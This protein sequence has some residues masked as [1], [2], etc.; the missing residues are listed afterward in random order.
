[1]QSERW[2]QIE[3]I[4]QSALEVEEGRRAAL[5]EQACAGDEDLRREVESLLAHHKDAG[6]FIESPALEMA[7]QALAPGWQTSSESGNSAA[8]LVGK[9]LSHYRVLERLGQGGM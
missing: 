7:A 9:T 8:G 3:Q 4:F 6:S 1:M 5:V 2:R